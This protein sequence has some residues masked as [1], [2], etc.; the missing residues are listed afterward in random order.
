MSKPKSS[1]NKNFKLFLLALVVATVI[2]LVLQKLDTLGNVFLVMLGF[3]MVILVHEFGHF[4]SAKLCG[5]K[6]E[7]FSIGFPPILLGFKK[8]EEGFRIRLLPTFFA[9][10]DPDSNPPAGQSKNE[11]D[12]APREDSL[13]SC[14]WGSKGKEWDT[15][16]CLGMIPVGGFVKMLGQEDSGAARSTDDP[17]S[18]ANKPAHSRMAVI[19]AGVICNVI[20]AAIIFMVVFLIGIRQP[21]PIVGGV[22]P[23][24]PAAHAG[25]M[26]GDEIIEID[27]KTKYLDMTDVM[28]AAALS[29]NGQKVRMKLD[30]DGELID[31][32]LA[33]RKTE[34]QPLKTF[35]IALSDSLEIGKFADPNQIRKLDS[36]TGLAPGDIIK[37][38]DGRPVEYYWQFAPVISSNYAP[39]VKLTTERKDKD[40]KSEIIDRELELDW[41]V[42]S[43]LATE[44]EKQLHH[45]YSMVPRL[46]VTTVNKV[47][48]KG[49]QRNLAG[50]IL[51]KILGWIGKA[52]QPETVTPDLKVDDIIL[53]VGQVQNPTYT[54]MREVTRQNEDKELLVKV[55]RAEAGG[56]EK[57][58]A[59]TVTPTRSAD[60]NDVAIG[61][62]L[63]LDA[64]HPVVA[65]TIA[66][67]GLA[68]LDI[69]PG[70][71]ITAIDGTPVA[72]F[73]DVVKEI[74]RFPGEH[75]TIQYR[76]ADENTAGA[77]AMVVGKDE[78]SI[79]V[80]P[81]FAEIIPFE[82]LTRLY[83]AKNPLEAVAM[84]G[85]K[86]VS[87]IAQTYLTIKRLIVGAVSP[88]SLMGP[89]GILAASY[90]TVAEK[91]WIEYLFLIGLIN[92]A[93]AVFN[94][95]P[96]P[97]LDGGLVLFLAIEKI[98]GSAVSERIQGLV[99]RAGWVFVLALFLYITLN[100]VIRNFFT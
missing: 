17:R 59:V 52:P 88:K 35:G 63:T 43:S 51:H 26:P 18:F 64:D 31:V 46:Q 34:G 87:M 3:G 85:R 92:A 23:N 13:W 89:V 19:S 94:F 28:L 50:R 70:A 22:E 48:R 72:T 55:L 36:T 96:L 71:L 42:G 44:D 5:I 53:A 99:I 6:V 32:A 38:V 78:K 12:P 84:G 47:V 39:T 56:A 16:Y 29:N 2:Y 60:T 66:A 61:I 62:A 58:V 1:A 20:L 45:I 68:R 80:K 95:L 25:L 54:Q 65:K 15:E 97:P 37:A 49:P 82:R 67:D 81:H 4:I 30:R 40:K 73:Y 76:L 21:P 9:E 79:T 90:Q 100:D 33:S 24:S 77:V 14:K 93:I 7:A 98:K 11:D 8:T 41:S 91:M 83:K 57:V 10:D 27:G 74:R 69:P 86:T 75:I